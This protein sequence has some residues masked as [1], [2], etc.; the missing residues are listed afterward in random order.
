MS[1][2]IAN[3]LTL[4]LLLSLGSITSAQAEGLKIG[5]VNV[6]AIFE[7]IPQ[8]EQVSRA[9]EAEFGE[10]IAAIQSLEQELE[11]TEAQLRRDESIMSRE[12]FGQA[13]GRFQ[14]RMEE[15]QR[16]SDAL[17]ERLRRRQGEE[18]ARLLDQLG[19]KIEQVAAARGLD[20]VLDAS[21]IAWL[22]T[23]VEADISDDVIRL[24]REQAQ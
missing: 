6:A 11:E 10:E 14:Q 9:L 2:R 21:A 5:V 20:M 24:M 4:T 13:V 18:R 19:E 23:G 8:R 12:Q 1:T 17:N 3:L 7:R 16:R 22:R 15:G